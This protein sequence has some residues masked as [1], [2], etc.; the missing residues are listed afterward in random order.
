MGVSGHRHDPTALYPRGKDPRYPLD[1]RLGGLRA[2]LDKED[3]GKILCPCRGWN[4][5]RPVVQSV[6]KVK[7]SSGTRHGGAWGER[8]YS[9]YSVTTSTLDGGEWSASRPYRSLP[10]GK[11]PSVSIGQDAGFASEPV[12]TQRLHEKPFALAGD[13]TSIARS[14]GP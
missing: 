8:R 1:R 14:S 4:P 7:S 3:R 6:G 9:C 10:P 2:G 5:D 13:R 12:W 11:G